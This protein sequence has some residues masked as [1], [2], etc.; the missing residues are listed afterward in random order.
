LATKYLTQILRTQFFNSTSKLSKNNKPLCSAF[1]GGGQ[2]VRADDLPAYKA[3]RY[4]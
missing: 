1:L 4:G 3:G 2:R